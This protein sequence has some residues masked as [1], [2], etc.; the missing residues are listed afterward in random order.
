MATH[1]PKTK[2]EQWLSCGT[3]I[4]I[5]ETVITLFIGAGKE[6]GPSDREQYVHV[7]HF[8]P[9]RISLNPTSLLTQSLSKMKF[10]L[11]PGTGADHP[12]DQSGVRLLM[13]HS[14]GEKG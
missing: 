13:V 1:E 6:K 9:L 7:L 2:M 12:N 4:D 3:K 5:I 10:I 11:T 8:L 14:S